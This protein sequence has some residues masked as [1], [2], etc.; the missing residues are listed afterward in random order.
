MVMLNTKY[1]QIYSTCC[2]KKFNN[3]DENHTSDLEVT[4]GHRALTDSGAILFK[5]NF[6]PSY[7]MTEV[8]LLK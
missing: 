1:R 2:T 6:L 5:R 4:V 3:T 8:I 7:T